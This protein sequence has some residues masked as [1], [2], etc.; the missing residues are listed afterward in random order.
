MAQYDCAAIIPVD[1]VRADYF[2]HL[3]LPEFLRK[4]GRGQI[5]LP[6]VRMD[7]S[8]KSARGVHVADLAA[9]L[10]ERRAAAAKELDAMTR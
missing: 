6:I 10:D 4:L 9:Y 7:D 8:Q 5:P 1:Q 2:W 3:S